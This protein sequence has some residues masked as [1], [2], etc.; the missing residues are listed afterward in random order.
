MS[1][2]YKPALTF[3]DQR[4]LPLLLKLDSHCAIRVSLINEGAA[5][6][7]YKSDSR[8]SRLVRAL[9]NPEPCPV[10][11][12]VTD[13]EI[14]VILGEIGDIWP[15]SIQADVAAASAEGFEKTAE[16]AP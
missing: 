13:N 12:M 8:Y 15:E 1:E 11:G 3:S 6:S 16:P 4:S 9:V 7:T 14:K 2:S 10:T 5:M